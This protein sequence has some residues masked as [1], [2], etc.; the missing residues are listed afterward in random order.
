MDAHN[1]IRV[2]SHRSSEAA[3]FIFE[4]AFAVAA[5]AEFLKVTVGSTQGGGGGREARVN[6][7]SNANVRWNTMWQGIRAEGHIEHEAWAK[8]W[9]ED[10]PTQDRLEGLPYQGALLMKAKN[11][12]PWLARVQTLI[13]AR[14]EQAKNT[15]TPIHERAAYRFGSVSA[16][17]ILV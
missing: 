11:P 15:S 12:P 6:W 17:A 4:A 9:S 10:S 13:S 2:L 14:Y 16:E 1:W 3:D 7:V 8:F 5:G